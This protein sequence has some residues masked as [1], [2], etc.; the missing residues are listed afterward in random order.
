MR[1]FQAWPR[2]LPLRLPVEGKNSFH[3]FPTLRMCEITRRNS[4]DRD[5]PAVDF[6]TFIKHSIPFAHNWMRD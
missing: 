5:V 3:E 1:T 6:N 4:S 2:I